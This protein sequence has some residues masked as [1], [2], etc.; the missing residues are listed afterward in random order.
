ME[1]AEK[2]RRSEGRGERRREIGEAEG[3]KEE[4]GNEN[5]TMGRCLPLQPTN[6]KQSINDTLPES[7]Q[8]YDIDSGDVIRFSSQMLGPI[9]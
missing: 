4:S 5:E 6:R 8:I 9:A 7:F 2:K 3:V 1:A